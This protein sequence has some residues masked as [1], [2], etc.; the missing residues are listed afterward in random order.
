MPNLPRRGFLTHSALA[1]TAWGVGSSTVRAEQPVTD[2][3][4]YEWRTYHVANASQQARVLGHLETAAVPAW[5]RLGIGPVGVFTEIGDQASLDVHL[6]L[7]FDTP[8][9][10]LNERLGLEGDAVYQKAAASY[11]ASRKDQP[12]FSRIDSSLLVAFAGQPK[13]QAPRRRPRV[14]ELRTY[15]SHSEAR[16]RRKIE[17][18]NEGEIPIFRDA[19]FETVLFGESL[20]GPGLPNLK[21]L[22][23]ADDM[24]ANEAG[25]QAF[26]QHPQWA[27]IKDLPR[28]ADT[29]SK[30]EKVLLQPAEF[31][32]V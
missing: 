18:F 23:A 28:Y 6:L 11:V 27:A 1:T 21:Y 2:R 24:A 16:A 22:L 9:A 30:I 15:H 26:L 8:Q 29:V 14:L 17:M 3:Q 12:A 20:V 4:Y 10:F 19:G 32:Q 7:T 25:W 31:S 13:L 5:G